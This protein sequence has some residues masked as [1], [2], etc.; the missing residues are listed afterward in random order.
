MVLAGDKQL[1][2]TSTLRA[3]CHVR[4]VCRYK[5]DNGLDAVRLIVAGHSLGGS[6][7]EILGLRLIVY[8]PELLANGVWLDLSCAV[9]RKSLQEHRAIGCLPSGKA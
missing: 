6:M 2:H 7:A 1:A 3:K 5:S 8:N 4:H 9:H